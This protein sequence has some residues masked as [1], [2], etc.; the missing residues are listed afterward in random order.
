VALDFFGLSQ[1]G[2]E[3]RSL[4]GIPLDQPA[5]QALL[6]S[7]DAHERLHESVIALM[8]SDSGTQLRKISLSTACVRDENGEMMSIVDVFRERE[9]DHGQRSSGDEVVRDVVA[10]LAERL[11]AVLL[12]KEDPDDKNGNGEEREVG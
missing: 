4:R 1:S 12:M 2:V 5:R 6:R 7:V 8:P 11:R 9:Q 3:G 10:E